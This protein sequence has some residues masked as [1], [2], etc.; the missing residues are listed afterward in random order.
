VVGF[1]GDRRPF[2][3]AEVIGEIFGVARPTTPDLSYATVKGIET[4]SAAWELMTAYA[5]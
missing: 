3:S 4:L 1:A 5:S 2:Q